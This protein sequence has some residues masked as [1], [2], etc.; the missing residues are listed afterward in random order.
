MSIR[1]NAQSPID[2]K[3]TL[4]QVMTWSH[5]A[6]SH[7][8][9]QCWPR[10]MSPYGISRPQW[11]IENTKSSPEPPP[12]LLQFLT[13]HCSLEQLTFH[14]NK[15]LPASITDLNITSGMPVMSRLWKA[16]SNNWNVNIYV[17]RVWVFENYFFR[18]PF[19]NVSILIWMNSM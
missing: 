14:N 16:A 18:K 6:F 2:D 8:L 3:L 19:Q 9:S 10:C 1:W 11:V 4:L 5:L 7:Y 12:E 15:K 17:K 13:Y